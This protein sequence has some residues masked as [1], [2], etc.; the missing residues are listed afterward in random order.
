MCCTT[1]ELSAENSDYIELENT[2][3]EHT[4][5]DEENSEIIRA[6]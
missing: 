6:K 3:S 1:T 2:E 4:E 5:S